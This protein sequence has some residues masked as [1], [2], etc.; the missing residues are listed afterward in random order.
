MITFRSALIAASAAGL[1]A[2]TAQAPAPADTASTPLAF[3]AEYACGDMKAEIGVAEETMALR[4]GGKEY[5]LAAVQTA[6]GAKYAAEGEGPETS[7]WSKGDNG[8]LVLEGV[9]FPECS[10]TGGYG[11]TA[12]AEVPATPKWVA[13]GHEPF[14]N[15]SIE[16]GEIVLVYDLGAE[17]YR[18]PAPEPEVIE[19]GRRY[20]ATPPVLMLTV[21]DKVC[22]DSMTGLP[23]PETVSVG[24]GERAF[25]GCGGDPNA[26]LAGAEWVVE[27]VNG[28]GVPDGVR[29]TLNFDAAT[30][31]VSG[32]TGCNSYGSSYS[33]GGEGITFG[34][35]VATEMA[36]P[37]AVMDL[38]QKFVAALRGATNHS[39]DETAAL[40]ITGAE[41]ARILARH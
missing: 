7:F 15:V 22:E 10:K 20:T 27:D 4:A 8:L 13:R 33:V 31:R 34:D 35:V 41:G 2:C 5:V 30:G 14:W 25:E 24:Y 28:G 11:E 18:T 1:A 38:E 23:Y 26:L 3:V 39:F 36:C 40:V 17:T 12:G 37:P 29:A 19:G 16:G 21:L 6:S 32:G 9:E